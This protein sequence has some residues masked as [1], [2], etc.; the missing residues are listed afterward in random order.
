MTYSD[1]I[2]SKVEIAPKSGFAVEDSEISKCLKPHQRDTVK[3]CI[4]GAGVAFFSVSVLAKLYRNLKSA[5]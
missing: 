3:W 2:D 4:E 5:D 1:F